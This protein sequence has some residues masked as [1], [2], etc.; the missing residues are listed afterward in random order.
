MIAYSEREYTTFCLAIK[1]YVTVQINS[2]Y[3]ISQTSCSAPFYF[4]DFLGPATTCEQ[5][6]YL[7]VRYLPVHPLISL[8]WYSRV[9]PHYC[10]LCSFLAPRLMSIHFYLCTSNYRS[11]MSIYT[12]PRCSI[13][14]ADKLLQIREK[15][16]QR[17]SSSCLRWGAY[18]LDH[19]FPGILC[20]FLDINVP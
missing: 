5:R 2:N 15:S 8:A 16:S 1:I 14:F 11:L 3:Y 18:Q 20:L 17:H 6:V 4:T 13:I 7:G 19:Y 10:S 9:Q 12:I